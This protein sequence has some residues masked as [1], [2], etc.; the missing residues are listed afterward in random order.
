MPFA[1]VYVCVPT[2][3]NL[4][5]S[6]CD[7]Q[8]MCDP[9]ST[10]GLSAEFMFHSLPPTLTGTAS[11]SQDKNVF[12]ELREECVTCHT[13]PFLVWSC[14]MIFFICPIWIEWR[15][16][17][18]NC[19]MGVMTRTPCVVDTY[20]ATHLRLLLFCPIGFST[21]LGNREGL[22]CGVSYAITLFWV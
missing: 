2:H 18:H 21:E 1:N 19:T 6:E 20:G 11:K 3:I 9:L 4:S 8:R 15:L 5:K 13:F 12:A 14:D 7:I 10:K 22:Y 16:L 17:L